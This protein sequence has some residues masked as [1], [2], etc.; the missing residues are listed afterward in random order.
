MKPCTLWVAAST[1]CRS[2]R[3]P[4]CM[5]F[6]SGIITGKDDDHA[7]LEALDMEEQSA[8]SAQ[9]AGGPLRTSAAISAVIRGPWVTHIQ[10][11]LREVCHCCNPGASTKGSTVHFSKRTLVC[12]RVT[13][14]LQTN[15]CCQQRE[16]DCFA[17]CLCECPIHF[18]HL[19]A[20][21]QQMHA[22]KCA[23]V[24]RGVLPGPHARQVRSTEQA[25]TATGRP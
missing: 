7:V 22:W 17:G 11:R 2:H 20:A 15:R 5:Q 9:P 1:T 24:A 19:P 6:P 25:C 21:R 8:F 18:R 14:E 13:V 3:A 23:C 10:G 12:I 4:I 16:L